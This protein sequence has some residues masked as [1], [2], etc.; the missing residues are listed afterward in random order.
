MWGENFESPALLYDYGL[1]LLQKSSS[2][3]NTATANTYFRMAADEGHAAS[4]FALARSL[5]RSH[6]NPEMM[7]EALKYLRMSA[8]AGHV[9][10]P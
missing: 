1:K 10:A 2:Q 3:R 6:P 4:A 5:I 8:D 7:A 9:E